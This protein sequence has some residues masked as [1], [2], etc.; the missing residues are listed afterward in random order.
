MTLAIGYMVGSVP[1]AVLVARR[2]GV[3]DLRAE[4]SYTIIVRTQVILGAITA[5]PGGAIS[6]TVGTTPGKTYR[7]EYKDDLNTVPWTTLPPDRLAAGSS[8]TINDTIGAN[9]QRFYR[10][11]QLD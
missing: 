7:V 3:P 5:G 1:V 9:P 11:L 8:L 2:N 4:R 6:F 10:V